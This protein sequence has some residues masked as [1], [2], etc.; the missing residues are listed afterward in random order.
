MQRTASIRAKEAELQVLNQSIIGLQPTNTRVD[1]YQG[2]PNPV[3][4]SSDMNW[5]HQTSNAGSLPP[6]ISSATESL[7]NTVHQDPPEVLPVV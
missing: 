5:S 3:E 6:P 1:E 4:N 7:Q 2:T